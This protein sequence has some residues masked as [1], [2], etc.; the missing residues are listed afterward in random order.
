[1]KK[2]LTSSK[3]FQYF[4]SKPKLKNW[5]KVEGFP[6][7]QKPSQPPYF[8]ACSNYENEFLIVEEYVTGH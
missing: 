8:S 6:K 2:P 3:V 5:A 1:M 7:V 4:L